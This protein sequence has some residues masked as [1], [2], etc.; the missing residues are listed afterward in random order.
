[1]GPHPVS[2]AEPDH[3]APAAAGVR[4][5]QLWQPAGGDRARCAKRIDDV[6]RA[7][8]PEGVAELDRRLAGRAADTRT[9]D[10]FVLAGA[11]AGQDC[12][13]NPGRLAELCRELE[14]AGWTAL[15][16]RE[17]GAGAARR[18]AR[19]F[20]FA[21]VYEVVE[22][23]AWMHVDR[24]RDDRRVV[25]RRERLTS[26]DLSLRDGVL[27]RWPLG[28]FV[29]RFTGPVP[30]DET[31]GVAPLDSDLARI[32]A[33]KRRIVAV[34]PEREGQCFYVPANGVVSQE[35]GDRVE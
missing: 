12:S 2:G 14:G 26:R 13:E 32:V 11:K 30:V 16:L 24:L 17:P 22:D 27:A 25:T 19:A 8:L 28:D 21:E 34:C 18:V 6:R 1:M 3:A 20:D 15:P 7:L 9:R 4:A 10:Y 35:G 23:D 31:D 29:A 33:N 5:L